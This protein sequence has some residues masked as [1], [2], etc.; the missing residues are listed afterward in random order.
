MLYS[1]PMNRRS[2]RDGD[3]EDEEQLTLKAAQDKVDEI[4]R[5]SNDGIHGVKDVQSM[6][7]RRHWW[8]ERHR[9]DDELRDL[10]QAI[11]DTWLGGFK[12]VFSEPASDAR[13]V[14]GLRARFEKIIRRA[15]FPTANKRPSKLKLDDA[16]FECFAGLPADCTDEDLEDLVHYVMDALQFSGFQV[17]VDEIDLDE[18][19]MD[20]RGALEEFRGKKAQTSPN[21]TNMAYVAVDE[22]EQVQDH[23][24]FLVLD[25]DTSVFPWESMPILRGRAVSRIPSMAFLQDRIEMAKVFCRKPEVDSEDADL[26]D[27]DL[28]PLQ[29]GRQAARSQSRS[30]SKSSRSVKATTLGTSSVASIDATI[31]LSTTRHGKLLCAMASSSACPNARLSTFSILAETLCKVKNASNHGSKDEVQLSDGEASS[32][33][34]PLSMSFPKPSPP[35]MCSSTLVTVERSSSSVNRKY[36]SFNDAPLPCCGVALQQCCTTMANS[37]VPVHRST[38]CAEVRLPWS[39]TCGI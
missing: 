32:A 21:K 9:L 19:A 31:A 4:V 24:I 2:Q 13:A 25:K 6:E 28:S 18:T 14:A 30:P 22:E 26:E 15:C 5:L 36:A 35:P 16:V 33:D 37:T 34:N 12:G 8:T 10:L 3:E 38:T 17:A 27:H 29:K 20:L 7:A 1:L 39:A 23:H 11:Q